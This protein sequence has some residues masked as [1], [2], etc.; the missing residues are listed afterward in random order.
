M[1]SSENQGNYRQS[2]VSKIEKHSNL[3]N[4]IMRRRSVANPSAVASIIISRNAVSELAT[5][6][7]SLMHTYVCIEYNIYKFCMYMCS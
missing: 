6:L 5:M 2:E 1:F 3:R 4:D 7:Y